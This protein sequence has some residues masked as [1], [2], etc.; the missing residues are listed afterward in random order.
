MKAL[1]ND[2][3]QPSTMRRPSDKGGGLVGSRGLQGRAGGVQRGGPDWYKG[4]SASS[5]MKP[6]GA[7]MPLMGLRL[8]PRRQRRWR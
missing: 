3:S 8:K 7:S 5:R 4:A 2:G 1:R 6:Y